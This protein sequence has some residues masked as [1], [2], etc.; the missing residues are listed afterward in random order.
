MCVYCKKAGEEREKLDT[1]REGIHRRC[2]VLRVKC[3][4][5]RDGRGRSTASGRDVETNQNGSWILKRKK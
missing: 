4:T 3:P 5:R 2:L 1:W